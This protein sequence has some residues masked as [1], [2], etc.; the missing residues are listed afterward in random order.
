[1]VS[2][3]VCPG[4]LCVNLRTFS[5]IGGCGCLCDGDVL[6]TVHHLAAHARRE[7]VYT[8]IGAQYSA[9]HLLALAFLP[10]M[11]TSKLHSR[12]SASARSAAQSKGLIMGESAIVVSTLTALRR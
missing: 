1:M 7:L 10:V 9:L 11:Q 12:A 3:D 2:A 8:L 5:F 4:E 6:E